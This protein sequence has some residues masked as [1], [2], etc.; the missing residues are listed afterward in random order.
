MYEM[1]D[2][3]RRPLLLP[4]SERELF[5]RY[6]A[7]LREYARARHSQREDVL[8]FRDL[9]EQMAGKYGPLVFSVLRT[10]QHDAHQI[11]DLIQAGMLA[12][13]YA[14]RRY[15]PDSGKG[16]LALASNCGRLPP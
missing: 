13:V 3:R 15:D 6:Q 1:Y 16:G 11:E 2:W 14:F 5:G 12:L 9:E 7:L 10:V 4:V 8:R